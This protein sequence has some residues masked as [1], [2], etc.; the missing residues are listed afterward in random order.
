MR[1]QPCC[2]SAGASPSRYGPQAGH[3]FHAGCPHRPRSLTVAARGCRV[4][5]GAWSVVRGAWSVVRGA[6]SVVR[7]AWSGIARRPAWKPGGGFTPHP[8]P[9]SPARGEG[10]HARLPQKGDTRKLK[11][12]NTRIP[13]VLSSA[14]VS[15]EAANRT[16]PALPKTENR[17]PA[18]GNRQP[19][20][21]LCCIPRV[22][23]AR[24]SG[25]WQERT[26][27]D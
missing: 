16:H 3:Q 15:C 18:T 1:A 24:I 11:E 8:R 14:I 2:G 25:A 10:C 23:L 5:R 22:L 12:E 4:E 7:E 21:P 26:E 19:A 20:S 27:R 6:W 13:A 17:K 9:L